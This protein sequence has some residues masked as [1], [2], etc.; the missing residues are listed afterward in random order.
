MIVE[1]SRFM[2]KVKGDIGL[3]MLIEILDL[4]DYE[5]DGAQNNHPFG[6][7]HHQNFEFGWLKYKLKLQRKKLSHKN[8]K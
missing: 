2:F 7:T 4:K 5:F 3:Q 6:N 1:I 8:Y